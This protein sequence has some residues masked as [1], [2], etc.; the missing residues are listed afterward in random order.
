[1]WNKTSLMAC[2]LGA[3]LVTLTAAHAQS[4][5]REFE[6]LGQVSAS[7]AR[8]GTVD[9]IEWVRR[10]EAMHEA[11]PEAWLDAN[12]RFLLAVQQRRWPEALA[13]LNAGG[14]DPNAVGADGFTAL[15]A[16]A[17]AGH[18]QVVR[19]LLQGGAH[20]DDWGATGLPALHLAC[21]TGQTAVID[22]LLRAG[23]RADRPNRHGEH[24]LDVAAAS[25]QVGVLIH[26]RDAGWPLATP[27]AHGLNALHAAAL[28]RQQDTAAWLQAQGLAPTT[29]L[30]ELMLDRMGAD[31]P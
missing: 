8:S 13:L 11:R 6:G 18:P 22:V 23:A 12:Q 24:A 1:M 4:A 27:D 9:P 19:A 14:V 15:G 2:G 21:T 5:S 10:S 3:A 20:L 31:Q 7:P 28:G 16:A 25:G 17:F 30:T 26:L 29:V